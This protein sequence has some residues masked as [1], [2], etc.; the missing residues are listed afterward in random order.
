MTGFGTR[1]AMLLVAAGLWSATAVRPANAQVVIT[2]F[3]AV[4]DN[5]LVDENGDR[6]DWIELHNPSGAPVNLA[7]WRLTDDAADL[8]K[9][10]F[11][12]VALPPNGYLVVFASNKD[13]TNA[14]APLHTNFR[15]D[16]DGEYLG[17]VKPDGITVADAYAPAY[18]PQQPDVSYGWTVHLQPVATLVP[19]GAPCRVL[20]PVD[21]ALGT[22]WIAGD[23]DDGAWLT[24]ATGVGY[25]RATGYEDLIATDVETLMYGKATGCYV[26]IA[27]TVTNAAAF[28][29]LELAMK[30]DDG[31]VAYLNGRRVAAAN[32]PDPAVW[33]AQATAEHPDSQAVVD[34]VFSVPDALDV[35]AGGTNLLAIHG[36]NRD[37]VPHVADFLLVPELRGMADAPTRD[38]LPAASPGYANDAVAGAVVC[39]PASRTFLDPVTVAL[40][41]VPS[42]CTIRYTLN[43]TEPTTNSALYTAPLTLT[44]S[45]R[46]RAR[47]YLGGVGGPLSY[48]AYCRLLPEAAAF[49]STTPLVIVDNFGQGAI[50]TLDTKQDAAM[51]VFE[52]VNGVTTLTNPPAIVTRVGLRTHGATTIRDAYHKPNLDV[53]SRDGAGNGRSIAPLGMPAE[54]DW[55][56]LAGWDYDRP[57]LRNPFAYE[58]CRQIGQYASRTRF[59]EVYLNVDGTPLTSLNY[60]GLYAFEERIK[61]GDQRVAI[62]K[63]S[64]ADNA[65]PAI[66]GGYIFRRDKTDGVTFSFSAGG[67]ALQYV[68]PDG[69][70]ITAA[71][72]TWLTGYIDAFAAALNGPDYQDDSVGYAAYIDVPNWI[73]EHILNM[74]CKCVDWP[75]FSTYFNKDRGG[76]LCVG[77]PWDFDRSMGSPDTRDIPHNTWDT[78]NKFSQA[79]WSRLFQDPDF[80]QQYVDRLAELR[81][82]PLSGSNLAG[83]IDGFVAEIGGAGDRDVQRWMASVPPAHGSWLG[84]VVDLKTWLTN[85]AAWIESQ[86]IQAPIISPA[87]GWVTP[88]TAVF[89]NVPPHTV[90][91]YTLDGSDPRA[92]GGTP[93]PAALAY[94]GPFQILTDTLV[95]ARAWNG[96][97][98]AG[99]PQY[100]PWS[101]LSQ[102]LY[103]VAP[104]RL[105]VAEVMYH[106][107][108]P[109]RAEAAQG[110]TS[111]DFEFIELQNVGPAAGGLLGARIDDGI[112]FDFTTGR[113]ARLEPGECVVVVRNLAAFTNRYPAW[114]SMKIAGGFEGSLSDAGERVEIISPAASGGIAFTYGSDRGWPEAADGAGHSLV[115]LVTDGQSNALDYGGH[116]RASAFIDGSPGVA[117]PEPACE[118]VLNEVVAHTDYSNAVLPEYDSNDWLELF[119]PAT[120]SVSLANW[121]LS[122]DKDDLRKWAIPPTNV[123][124]AGAWVLFD[125]VSGFHSPLTNGFG[126]NKAGE[127]VFLSHLPGGGLDRV[128]DAVRFKGQENGVSLGRYRDG[129]T[130][131]YALTPPTP[132]AANGMLTASVVI[133]E[134]LYHPATTGDEALV[135]FVE[136]H[137]AGHATAQLWTADGP[138]RLDGGVSYTFP[139]GVTLTPQERMA[140]VGFD[141]VSNAVARANFLAAYGLS[142]GQVRLYGPYLGQL[143]N[144]GERLALEK[145]LAPD[146]PIEPLV[147]V[148][149]DEVIYF[150]NVPW[151][152]GADGTGRSLARMQ[153]EVS[154]RDPANWYVA[155]PPTPGLGP[156]R[157]GL[158]TPEDEAVVFAQND[159]LLSAVVDPVLVTGSSPRVAFYWGD[160]RL[161]TDDGAPFTATVRLPAAGRYALR[162]ELTDAEGVWTSRTVWV[163]ALALSNA[164][165][166]AVDDLTATAQGEL[167]GAAPASVF[168]HWGPTDGGTNLAAWASAAAVGTV[169][170][171]AFSARLD[172]LLP[173]RS[174]AVRFSA[175]VGAR[176]GWSP[177]A[178]VFTTQSNTNWPYR[179]TIRFD[180]YTDAEPL[181][182]FPALVRF[183]TNLAGFAYSQFGGTWASLRFTDAASGQPLPY[184]VDVWN[185]NGESA[186][187]VRVPALTNGTA[188]RAYWGLVGATNPP[189][190]A[191]RGAVW[192]SDDEAVW[193]WQG[194]L[195]DATWRGYEAVNQGATQTAGVVG[196]G[197]GFDGVSNAIVLPLPASWYGTNLSALTVSLW[198]KPAATQAWRATP[199]GCSSTNAALYLALNSDP[200]TLKWL[201]GFGPSEV[202][203]PAYDPGAWQLISLVLSNGTARIQ[204]NDGALMVA[205]S[206]TPFTPTNAP[207]L[208]RRAGA[209]NFFAGSVDEVR[210]SRA[211]RSAAWLRAAYRTVA[212]PGSFAT[213]SPV[214]SALDMDADGDGMPDAWERTHFVDTARDGTG[215]WDRDGLRDGDEYVAGTD[216][217]NAAS[218]LSMFITAAA[219]A[220]WVGFNA[221][222]VAGG[223][224]EVRLYSLESA[225][226]LI[227]AAWSGVPGWTNR[228]GLAGDVFYTNPALDTPTFYRTKTWLMPAAP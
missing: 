179:A 8:T 13:R 217:T 134:F 82:G 200:R 14:A 220:P 16:G 71:Q 88:G 6:S 162:A 198:V 72:K 135:E 69:T 83:T 87:G 90:G 79:W 41:V 148:I 97:A 66:T 103:I 174:H 204:K 120:S 32:A 44:N 112:A 74:F 61:R 43:G 182:N 27:F 113:V 116:W 99:A 206:Y 21:G 126:L 124:Q 12:A 52:P 159:E 47:A 212:Q 9:W 42:D 125:E 150:D 221:V 177:A 195:Q 209:G 107:R 96:A 170:N 100:G 40:A 139:A 160:E 128:V 11:P 181:A 35:L 78:G 156:G 77:P 101:P 39:V 76:K 51:M 10:T 18:P 187:W 102:A 29:A 169:S 226:S 38:V 118:V 167:Q 227:E 55:V 201:S 130:Y 183:G 216:P 94:T 49:Q 26:R 197:R 153:P 144:R 54:S 46:V 62:A 176:R 178:T 119:N 15:L 25:D 98:F 137:N 142:E 161:D 68:Y 136:V 211:V 188:I 85:R 173:G 202:P 219:A 208:G 190:T 225:T 64:A 63:L 155:L 57:G 141:P 152:A 146:L 92:P 149:V 34:E 45:T 89:L 108:A 73:D 151:P 214:E 67:S 22:N 140:V 31:F 121:F 111:G 93:S 168:V 129:E 145:P 86:I 53:E 228:D 122:D 28:D 30:Y 37:A 163:T 17:L 199:F 117:D 193:H 207:V 224:D 1:W 192:Q 157:V 95:Q 194:G 127:T 132:W 91:Y 33:S 106:P 175:V 36:L 123:L 104:A 20:V 59:C 154:G 75:V 80:W 138:W 185:T 143:D 3:L 50:P 105:A 131:W 2:E 23:F 164:V 4:N 56:L 158:S 109:S 210:L 24:G 133:S 70:V 84:D 223:V 186:V 189:P 180:G 110:F 115:P 5:G 7:G 58:L 196:A 165:V 213:Y 81:R 48:A 114:L 184:E 166:T 19:A 60:S 147:W 222:P 215:D 191:A 218:R 205:G 203:G 65:E 172:G 171:A